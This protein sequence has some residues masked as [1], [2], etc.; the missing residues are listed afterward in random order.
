[1]LLLALLGIAGCAFLDGES[2]CP[3]NAKQCSAGGVEICD[4][5]GINNW[6]AG[7]T[8]A[9]ETPGYICIESGNDAFCAEPSPSPACATAPAGMVACDGNDLVTCNGEY[10]TARTDC[11]TGGTSTCVV[12][13]IGPLCT[14]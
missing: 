11:A 4:G 13:A 10:V 5:E 6:I 14:G 3:A 1:V 9:Q 12:T 8:C 7:P 2:T